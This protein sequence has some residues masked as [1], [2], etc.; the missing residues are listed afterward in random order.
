M[1]KHMARTNYL[2]HPFIARYIRIYPVDWKNAIAMRVGLLGKPY[3]GDC[4]PGFTRPNKA[5]P[6]GEFKP[7]PPITK[8]K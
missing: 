3:D 8:M 4:V 7:P 2:S 5:S 1:D 6:C